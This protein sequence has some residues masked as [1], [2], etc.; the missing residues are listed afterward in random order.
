MSRA[1]AILGICLAACIGRSATAH[2]FESSSNP[3]ACAPASG[4]TC[5]HAVIDDFHSLNSPHPD[6]LGEAFL[7]L[8]A[9]RTELRY[10]L[11]IDGL[12]LKPNAADRTA[13]DDVIGIH[14]H[15]NVPDTVGPHLLNIFGLATYNMPA[16]EDSDL[17]VNFADRTLSGVYDDGDATIDPATGQ[18]FLPFFPLPSKPLSNWLEHLEQGDLMVA[19]HTNASGFPAMAIHG[20]ISQVVPEPAA[21]ILLAIAGW[22]CLV[23]TRVFRA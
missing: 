7:A 23:A 6:A 19:V 20:H 14:L 11:T 15:L 12:N 10:L 2:E 9:Q 8:N 1:P 17:V 4:E 21:F 16:E 13:L 3:L 18:P 22:P 5:Y